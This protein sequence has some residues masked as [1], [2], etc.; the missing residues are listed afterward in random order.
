[1]AA[2]FRATNVF[3]QVER[4][5]PTE[6]TGYADHHRGVGCAF[7]LGQQVVAMIDLA[8]EHLGLTGSAESAGAGERGVGSDLQDR[9]EHTLVRRNG[10]GPAAACQFHVEGTVSRP[11]GR[12]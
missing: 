3:S 4:E 7:R 12:R 8:G 11:I 5:S 6:R 10:H 1:M 2:E 9:L